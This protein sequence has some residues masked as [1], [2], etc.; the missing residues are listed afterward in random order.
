MVTT[1]RPARSRWAE[2]SRKGGISPVMFM[3]ASTMSKLTRS[4]FSSR[5]S[6]FGSTVRR[7]CGMKTEI[8]PL[9]IVPPKMLARTQRRGFSAI[10]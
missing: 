1:C 7:S 9:V 6:G 5:C 4:S 3:R 8:W 10:Q 2:V